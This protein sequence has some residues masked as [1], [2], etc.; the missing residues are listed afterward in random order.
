M[1]VENVKETQEEVQETV[2]EKVTESVTGISWGGESQEI[3]Q[4]QENQEVQETTN[5]G[6]EQETQEEVVE[7]EESK[8][9]GLFEGLDLSTDSQQETKEPE[10]SEEATD[11]DSNPN[12]G[13]L[14]DFT[15]I[16][17]I[18][19][20]EGIATQDD[21]VNQIKTLQGK[22]TEFANDD[23]AS[24]SKTINEVAKN[25]GDWR[26]LQTSQAELVA[27]EKGIKEA[28][29]YAKNLDTLFKENVDVLTE[30]ALKELGYEGDDLQ[31]ELENLSELRKR[32]LAKRIYDSEMQV[33]RT[34]KENLTA[35]QSELKGQIEQAAQ[36]AQQSKAK[37][38]EMFKSA[39]LEYQDADGDK[40]TTYTQQLAQQ[41]YNT[42]PITITVPRGILKAVGLVD[43]GGRFTPKGA[44][45]AIG[46][47]NL[48]KLKIKHLTNRAKTEVKKSIFN[49]VSNPD[50]TGGRGEKQPKPTGNKERVTGI[51][52]G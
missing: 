38:D 37:A 25:G 22:A 7:Q 6:Q 17:E 33:I 30:A 42:S 21:L 14:I 15:A 23:V 46:T 35:K 39:V 26:V 4:S 52:W 5:E 10:S 34:N 9:D 36:Q 2:Q 19:G 48:S 44:I 50:M 45:E 51:K 18:L 12:E 32:E 8:E 11:T 47:A 31:T 49:K 24:Y 16:G 29:E 43:D 40:F 3:Q 13:A 20:F 27:A 1:E 41:A 28:D